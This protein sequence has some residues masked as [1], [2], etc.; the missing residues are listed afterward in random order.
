M[1]LNLRPSLCN[2][3]NKR[4]Q[5]KNETTFAS[6]E[7]WRGDSSEE[8]V[9]TVKFALSG[10]GLRSL[11]QC[12]QPPAARML[13]ASYSLFVSQRAPPWGF[14]KPWATSVRYWNP[15]FLLSSFSSSASSISQLPRV[16]FISPCSS[17]FFFCFHSPQ[18]SF[19][20]FAGVLNTKGSDIFLSCS[21]TR[22]GQNP[23]YPVYA[24]KIGTSRERWIKLRDRW[25]ESASD[26]LY[27]GKTLST[28]SL[29]NIIDYRSRLSFISVI[30]K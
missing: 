25:K 17:F 30:W 2:R 29:W 15:L 19:S 24:V 11:L 7:N 1:D 18:S 27:D 23:F 13:S 16:V 26:Y 12:V 8:I 10:I 28:L 5:Q 22:S 4:R 20:T 6:L 9:F 21:P 14:I 3:G